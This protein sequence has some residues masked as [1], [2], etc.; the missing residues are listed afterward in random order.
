MITLKAQKV[1][2]DGNYVVAGV[3]I[4]VE[5]GDDGI[6]QSQV[7]VAADRFAVVHGI[8]GE[9]PVT[10]FVIE[11]GQT[12][13][14]NALIK[15]LGADHLQVNT[16]SELT[17]DA[18]VLVAGKLQGTNTNSYIDLNATGS[19][20]VANWGNGAMTV[21]ASGVLTINQANVIDSLNI[22]DGAVSSAYDALDTSQQ[23][24]ELN[25]GGTMSESQTLDRSIVSLVCKGGERLSINA[26]VD[27]STNKNDQR[28]AYAA[29]ALI[30][31]DGVILRTAHMPNGGQRMDYPNQMLVWGGIALAGAQNYRIRI[32][33]WDDG[34]YP[35]WLT[36]DYSYLEV[37]VR[38]K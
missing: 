31:H 34:G 36:C 7:L 22:R 18:G 9:N 14:E 11:G 20:F 16:L 38:K 17:P 15:N 12:F 5:Q 13:I 27:F 30:R 26:V 28:S 25:P 4:G 24:V 19:D 2:E 35:T 33:V 1:T 23:T 3:G 21:S 6:V 8:E 10:P 37:N 29:I 32:F